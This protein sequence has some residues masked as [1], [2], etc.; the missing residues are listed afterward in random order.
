MSRLPLSNPPDL[1]SAP[2]ASGAMP[3][4]GVASRFGEWQ[5]QGFD[6]VRCPVRNVLDVIGD[7]WST[8]ILMSLA[9]KARRFSDMHRVIPDISKRMLTQTLRTLEREGLVTRHV[10]PTKPPSVE[11]RLSPLG[12]SVLVP[13]GGLIEWAEASFD[14]IVASRRRFDVTEVGLSAVQASGS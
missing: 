8:L 11:Y 1:P 10:F 5:E 13:L 9:S 4:A 12:R 6:A 3:D 7:K 2:S 14:E